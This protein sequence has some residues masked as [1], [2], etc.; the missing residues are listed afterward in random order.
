MDH[1]PLGRATRATGRALG[2]AT[3]LL[4]L[5]ACA[6]DTDAYPHGEEAESLTNGSVVRTVLLYVVVPLLV[7]LSV[8]ALAWLP[9]MMRN[10]R[11]RP[12]EGWD[13]EPVWFAGPADP[14]AAVES[15]ETG[16]VVRGGAGGSW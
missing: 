8:A 16:D 13:A 7:L 9:A 4:L 1:R 2:A 6:N 11:Y 14:V 10:K 12:R 5:A 15:A 3:C